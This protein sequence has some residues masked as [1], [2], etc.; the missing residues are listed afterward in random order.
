MAPRRRGLS[1]PD[2]EQSSIAIDRELGSRTLA[3][4][5]R[6]A[7]HQVETAPL[8]WNWHLD[9]IAEHLE[10]VSRGQIRDLI[11]NVP[12]GMTKS[13]SAAT[14]W[15]AWHWISDPAHKFIFSTYGQDLSDK[16]ARLH[17]DLQASDWY[18]RRWP[19]S[20]LAKDSAAKVREFF[21]VSRGW[22]YSTS[23]GGALTGRHG[24]TLVFDDLVKAQDAEGRT[25]VDPVAIERANEFWFSTMHTRRADPRTT[26]RVGIM[27]RL[28]H[29][30][31][32][33]KCIERG[34]TAL[35][36]PMEYDPARRCVVEVT[37]FADPRTTE[38]ELLNPDRFP[39]EVVDHDKVQ[40]GARAFASQM[41]QNPSPREGAIFKETHFIKR[42]A[43][44]SSARRILTVDCTFKD[45]A[46]SDFVVVQ[47]W[48]SQAG[49]YYLLGQIRD[50]MN[51][52]A[53]MDAIREACERWHPLS[54][55]VEDKA[56]GPAVIDLLRGE[57][58]MI[59]PW[60][61]GR[62]GKVERAEAVAPVFEAGAVYF[63]EDEP[64]WW[65]AYTT[66]MQQFPMGKHDDQVDATTMAILI[67]HKPKR[68][69]YADAVRKM[70]GS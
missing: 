67:L 1:E 58:P 54:V 26:R 69:R 51:V 53:T 15:P 63:P 31:T 5:M 20:A 55:Y 48:A 7:W 30:D 6:L 64:A 4:F 49:R 52:S 40:M 19:A 46:S 11:I 2:L 50:R 28:H 41:Q 25:V 16:S 68:A 22:R 36:L 66:E 39:R 34:Y 45:A 62:S 24:D 44:P 47:A 56:N 60:S 21:N 9:A 29:E 38:G 27:Q 8:R 57:L 32:A 23:V 35:I 33:S 18:S 14:L 70:G 42:A 12:P 37:G 65:G 10:A 43:P 3:D 59:V 13:L 17:R 61:P